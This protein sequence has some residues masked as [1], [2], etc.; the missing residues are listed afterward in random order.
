MYHRV[1]QIVSEI[2]VDRYVVIHLVE[3]S[4]YVSS[5]PTIISLLFQ[6]FFGPLLTVV[7]LVSVNMANESDYHLDVDLC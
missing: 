7:G 5:S 1:M 4:N 2:L 6:F 3:S